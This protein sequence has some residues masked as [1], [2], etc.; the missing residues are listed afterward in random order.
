MAYWWENWSEIN[1]RT[2][3][4]IRNSRVGKEHVSATG[5]FLINNSGPQE[6]LNTLKYGIN[7]PVR[8]LICRLILGGTALISY[9]KLGKV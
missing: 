6:G 7:V 8:L 2:G 4:F 1:K 3:T 5:I 9:Y